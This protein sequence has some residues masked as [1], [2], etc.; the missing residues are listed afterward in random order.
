MSTMKIKSFRKVDLYEVRIDSVRAPN[1]LHEIVKRLKPSATAVVASLHRAV[2]AH[3]N[4]VAT[5]VAALLE[6]GYLIDRMGQATPGSYG[7]VDICEGRG[8]EVYW[9]DLSAEG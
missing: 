6:E 9:I 7:D 1:G 2:V 8:D 5:V 4:D 3:K